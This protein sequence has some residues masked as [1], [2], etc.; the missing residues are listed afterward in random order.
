MLAIKRDIRQANISCAESMLAIL[1]SC[2]VQSEFGDF[3]A[4]ECASVDYIAKLNLL[5]NPSTDIL[6][7]IRDLHRQRVGQKERVFI[8]VQFHAFHHSAMPLMFLCFGKIGNIILAFRGLFM[9]PECPLCF[10]DFWNF[11]EHFWKHKGN[12]TVV[13]ISL[14]F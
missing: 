13:K 5:P 1:T 8:S 3:D 11:R 6:N 4:D 7:R 14:L 9:F 2:L 12:R 10:Q